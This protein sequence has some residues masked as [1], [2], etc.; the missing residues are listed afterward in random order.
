M[1]G[2]ENGC[3]GGFYCVGNDPGNYQ[4][5]NPARVACF[6]FFFSSSSLFSGEYSF[7]PGR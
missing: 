6:V 4:I 2:N 7:L 1:G 3:G 5:A